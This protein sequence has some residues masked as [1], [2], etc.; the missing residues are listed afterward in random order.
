[1]AKILSFIGAQQTQQSRPSHGGA[2]A[3]HASP[4]GCGGRDWTNQELS[5]LY[6]TVAAL[7]QAGMAVSMDRGQTDEGDP[8]MVLCR[9]DGEV[10]IHFCRLDGR[11][12]LDSP[13]LAQPLRGHD[14]A[15][16]IDNFIA[17]AARAAAPNVVAFRASK[18]FLHP[19]ALLTMLVWSLYVWSSDTSQ[20]QAG[21]TSAD[22]WHTGLPEALVLPGQTSDGGA[23][24]SR[25]GGTRPG[26]A[27]DSSG[28]EKL[29]SRLLHAVDHAGGMP[30]GNG[31]AAMHMLAMI[32]TLVLS[33]MSTQALD[34]AGDVDAQTAGDKLAGLPERPEQ[35]PEFIDFRDALTQSGWAGSQAAQALTAKATAVPDAALVQL[36]AES[37][38]AVAMAEKQIIA[39][40]GDGPVLGAIDALELVLSDADAPWSSGLAAVAAPKDAVVLHTGALANEFATLLNHGFS[41]ARYEVS[42]V[43]LVASFDPAG[44][45]DLQI[46]AATSRTGLL[47]LQFEAPQL[48]PAPPAAQDGTY[49]DAARAFISS[50]LAQSGEIEV[51]ASANELVLI[52]LTAFDDT[53]DRAYAY[54][55]S[56]DDGGTI[57]TLGHYE[58]FASYALV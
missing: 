47:H 5:D 31:V 25:D 23:E 54:S 27:F 3:A 13:A 19:A 46:A 52:D 30:A 10:F 18:V 33:A 1:M 20:V 41:L 32:S 9:P 12:V 26:A 58:F 49:S 8:W 29:A 2:A 4:A 48:G 7:G 34:P 16:L 55:W 44:L 45:Q 14:F 43:S 40:G 42:G 17:Q 21:E 50:F 56:L 15:E 28:P 53:M 35:A 39:I 24:K 37:D 57:S 36:L 11:Y 6:R 51:L 38:G 22:D